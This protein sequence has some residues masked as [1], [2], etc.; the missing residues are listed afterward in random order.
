M[1]NKLESLINGRMHRVDVQL[2]TPRYGGRDDQLLGDKGKIFFLKVTSFLFFFFL[3]S[4]VEN[5][6]GLIRATDREVS[7]SLA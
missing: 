2:M 7:E 6:L 4:R 3:S 1:F 5:T